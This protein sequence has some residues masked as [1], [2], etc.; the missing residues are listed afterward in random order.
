MPPTTI[1]DRGIPDSLFR[2]RKDL[3]RGAQNK[4]SDPVEE[5]GRT[6]EVPE[7]GFVAGQDADRKAVY[8]CIPGF[9]SVAN[10]N[11]Q[12]ERKATSRLD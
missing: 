8:L 11:A 6:R 7:A 4:I 12:G 9:G 3:H 2:N 1:P 5:F 10:R